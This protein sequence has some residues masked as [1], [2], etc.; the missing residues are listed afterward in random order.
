MLFRSP[1]MSLLRQLMSNS[2]TRSSGGCWTCRVRRK[3]CAENKPVCDT[4]SALGIT[5]YFG[6]DRPAWMDGGPRQRVM[7]EAIK[8]QVKKQASQRRDRRY[9]EMLEAGT[10]AVTIADDAEPAPGA[11]FAPRP[12]PAAAGSLSRPHSDAVPSPSFSSTTTPGSANTANTTTKSTST[13]GASPPEQPWHSQLLARHDDA[14]ADPNPDADIHFLM[15][16]LDY[17]FPYLFPHYR[18]S[19]LAGGRGWVLDVLQSNKCV[20]HTAISLASSFFTVVLANG[21]AEHEQCTLSMVHKLES[22]LELGLSELRREMRLLT[23]DNNNKAGLDRQRAL[24]VMQS[25][26]QMLFF[27]LATSNKDNWRMHLDAAL[28]LFHRIVPSPEAWAD[29]L[30]ALY[31]PRWPP[32]EIGLRRPWSTNQAALRFFS[33]TLFYIDVLS[34][35]TLGNAPR[36][37]P[38]HAAVLPACPQTE[39]C[40]EPATAGPL[41]LDDFFGLP[42]WIVHALADVAALESWKKVQ[43]QAGSLSVGEL[44]SRANAL[45]ATIRQG[46]DL[47]QADKACDRPPAARHESALRQLLVAD[48]AAAAAAAAASDTGPTLPSIW[49]LATLAYLNVVVNGWQPSSPDV[50]WPVARA[51]QLLS[52]LP[53]GSCLRSLAWPMCVCGCLAPPDDEPAYRAMAERLGPLGI[54]GTVKEAMGIMEKVWSVRDQLDESWDVSK[55]LNILGHGVL[56][57]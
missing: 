9:L 8:A 32:P 37:R 35:V 3:K 48:P 50:R 15:I 29:T 10:R 13:T 55:C 19:I 20:Y 30:A 23:A 1:T 51:T 31:T 34:S 43:K 25:I 18:P 28:F 36:L 21:Q 5:C 7:A 4:C 46:L 11:A 40:P 6:D 52:T 27:E 38:Y 39:R 54:F 42:N 14:D 2:R 47:M 26:V 49:L 16:Y 33:A 22:Q 57:I 41:F 17:V 56:L 44:V 24:V 45:A 53:P 12:A